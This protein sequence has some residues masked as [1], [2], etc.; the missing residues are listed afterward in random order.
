M[1]YYIFDIRQCKNKAQGEK[2]KDYLA[3]LGIGGEYVFP[4]QARTAG[5]LVK[6]ALSR[7]FS[8]IVAIGNDAIINSVATELVGEKA[9]FGIIPLN[10]SELINKMV[11]GY[12][13]RQAATNLRYRKIREIKLGRMENGRHFLT[14]VELD[15]SSPVNITLEFDDFLAQS[16]AK[17]LIVSNFNPNTEKT[18]PDMLDVFLSSENPNSSSVV[19]KL[20]SYFDNANQDSSLKESFFRTKRVRV[21]SQK[22]LNFTIDKEIV[23]T[24]PQLICTSEKSLRLITSREILPPKN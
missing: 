24:T 22:N 1:Y 19:K 7:D 5:E 6:D 4:S 20:F 18:A 13:W 17:K 21:F 23:G 3:F 14:E 2:I 9:A 12:D 10:A 15:I 11:N 8:T 16:R